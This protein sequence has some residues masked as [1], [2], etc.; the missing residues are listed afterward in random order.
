MPL[1]DLP[2][3]TA[4]PR[5]L[6]PSPDPSTSP[7]NRNSTVSGSTL[8]PPRQSWATLAIG[9]LTVSKMRMHTAESVPMTTW[10]M[11]DGAMRHDFRI[12]RQC[13][14][15]SRLLLPPRHGTGINS[16]WHWRSIRNDNAT[17]AMTMIPPTIISFLSQKHWEQQQSIAI[18]ACYCSEALSQ[19]ISYSLP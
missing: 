4:R 10:V 16:H 2:P 7:F 13:L 8:L 12:L 18:K 11:A 9:S 3:T 14:A 17:M 15:T 6:V 1:Q 19:E 5:S